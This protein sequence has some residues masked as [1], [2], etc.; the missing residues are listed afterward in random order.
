MGF[1]EVSRKKQDL[2]SNKESTESAFKLQYAFH[3]KC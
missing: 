2:R 3:Y 1:W